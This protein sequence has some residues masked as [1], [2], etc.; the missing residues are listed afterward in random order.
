LVSSDRVT[1]ALWQVAGNPRHPA[2]LPAVRFLDQRGYGA[3]ESG[4][5]AVGASPG[6]GVVAVW[7]FGDREIAF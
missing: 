2:W 3:I 4:T 6:G 1:V 5:L 7:K